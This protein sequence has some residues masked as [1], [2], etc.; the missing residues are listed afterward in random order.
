LRT[1]NRLWKLQLS[2]DVLHSHAARLGSDINFL[3]SGYR[4]A[5]CGGRGERVEPVQLNGSLQGV[6]VVPKV[7]NSTAEVFQALDGESGDRSPDGLL[8][9]L[10]NGDRVAV[11]DRSFNRLQMAAC[12]INKPIASV[13]GRLSA[14]N[15]SA[16]L[17]GS[18][19][20]CFTLTETPAQTTRV[21]SSLCNIQHR[22]VC[23]FRC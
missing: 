22:M 9:A 1:L 5:V 21:M 20:A 18:G 2:E 4:A 6:V 8:L 10:A 11:V 13:L 23:H 19:S 7:G 3:L 14:L 15:G 12:R 16:L 17:T